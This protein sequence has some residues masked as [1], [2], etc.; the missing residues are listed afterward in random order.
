MAAL[1]NPSVQRLRIA[2]IVAA[3]ALALGA[4]NQRKSLYEVERG[5]PI[6]YSVIDAGSARGAPTGSLLIN[7]FR[8]IGFDPTVPD[9]FGRATGG[10]GRYGVQPTFFAAPFD[11]GYGFDLRAV[12][13]RDADPR[14]PRPTA[15]TISLPRNRMALLDP[16]WWEVT[17]Q[18]TVTGS[19]SPLTA[20]QPYTLVLARMALVV[21][22]ELDAVEL[23]LHGAITQPDSLYYLGGSPTGVPTRNCGSGTPQPITA[24]SNPVNIGAVVAGASGEALFLYCIVQ[25][26]GDSP[27]WRRMAGATLPP[28]A[29]DSLPLGTNGPGGRVRPGQYNYLLLFQ[30]LG[31]DAANPIP[32]GAPVA[33]IQIGP[34]IDATG[35]VI[36][37]GF[38][39]FPAGKLTDDQ[40]I[41]APGGAGAPSRLT[42]QLYNLDALSSKV[43]RPWL[44]NPT[45]GEHAPAVISVR[46][47]REVRT[48][49][50]AGDVSIT[51]ET[52]GNEER[53]IGFNGRGGPDTY[54]Y[55]ITVSDADLPATT[56]IGTF[57]H[58]ALSIDELAANQPSP[59]IAVWRQF[60]DQRGTPTN[61][62]DDVF[63]PGPTRFG[64]LLG[65]TAPYVFSPVGS[66]QA[67]FFGS[68][69]RIVLTNVARPPVGFHYKGWLVNSRT[70]A[71]V[72]LGGLTTLPPAPVSLFNADVDRSLHGVT[73]TRIVDSALTVKEQDFGGRFYQYDQIQITLE[74]KDSPDGTISPTIVLQGPV[75]DV[76][77]AQRP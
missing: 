32:P 31:A 17:G 52:V 71:R 20:G 72:A 37:N 46:T 30:G 2:G 29:A 12:R 42:M 11:I 28:G 77:L 47:E 48:V 25:P 45:T 65:N 64:T 33:R 61:Y 23:M 5:T 69:L 74:A 14:S 1:Y 76:I 8:L 59:A 27:W 49:S 21:R 57:T 38:S 41:A 73:A 75:P 50:D 35:A 26:T 43:Y 9:A 16:L 51:Y 66:G 44:L 56:P 19:F 34:D 39:P 22:G 6:F 53:V 4:C 13:G 70:G 67:D 60:T 55:T 54:R 15:A 68:E 10:V 58:L 62:F 24:S 18:W 40:L 7:A 63:M 36:E 3:A